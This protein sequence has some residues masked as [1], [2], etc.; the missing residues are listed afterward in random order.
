MTSLQLYV[1]G[2]AL[3][4]PSIDPKCIVVESYLRLINQEYTIVRC[5]DPHM[6]P[7]GELPLLKDGAVWVAGVD[8]IITHLSNHKKDS[9]ADL[10]PEQK[11][12]YLAYSTL[13][14]NNLYDSML[15]TW[16]ADSTNFIKAIRPTYAKLLAFPARYIVPI[17]LKSNAQARLSRYNV[18]ITSDDVGLP[19]N[20]KEEMKELLKSGWHHMYRLAR[21]TY[22]I[23]QSQLDDKDYMFGTSPTTLDCIVFGYLALHLYPELPHKRLQYIL[24]NEYPT[25]AQYC[26]RLNN[27]LYPPEQD[28]PE[29]S[30]SEDVPSLW[31]TIVNNPKEFL[32]SVKSDIV[33]YMGSEEEKKEKSKSQVDFERKRI[34][35]IAGGVTVMLAYVIYNGIISIAPQ[36]EFYEVDDD[37]YYDDDYED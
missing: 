21:E 6:S 2:S 34:W 27:L 20:E 36:E 11:A 3:N 14:Q 13:A 18:E 23:L 26:E 5:N 1:W 8:R 37:G 9:N 32:S 4:A 24:K 15:Y 7:T 35:S 19:Q 22:S 25:L 30:P 16:Y 28:T 17:Q 12:D 29:S 10:S 31:R 33:S